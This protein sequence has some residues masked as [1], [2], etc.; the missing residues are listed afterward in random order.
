[1]KCQICKIEQAEW[2][3]QPF[4]PNESPDS[5]MLLGSHYRGF[6]VIKVGDSCK[7]AFQTGDFEVQ[8]EYKGHHFLGKDHKVKEI[9][10]SLWDGGTTTLWPDS[11]DQASATMIMKDAIGP[12]ELVAL[13][14][15]PELVHAFT[16]APQLVEACEELDKLYKKIYGH[17]DHVYVPNEDRNEIMLALAKIHVAMEADE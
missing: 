3:W 17:L 8:F 7:S 12:S 15:V 1:M 13:V 16:V 2:A 6:P 10:I 4:G 11:H 9:H 5:Y 14:L